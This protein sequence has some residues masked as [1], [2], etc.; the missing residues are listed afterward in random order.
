MQNFSFKLLSLFFIGFIFVTNSHAHTGSHDITLVYTG[1]IDGELEPCGCSEGGNKGGIKRRVNAI[2][3]LRKEDPNLYLISAG[4]VLVSDMPQ[5]RLKSEYLLKGFKEINYDAI[6]VQWRDLAFGSKFLIDSSLPFI[7]SNNT[8]GEFFGKSLINN[9]HAKIAFFS[10][11]DP[12]KSPQK[13]MKSDI[14][15]S[16]TDK[17]ATALKK[18]KS[19]KQLTI[20]SSTLSLKQAQ[21]TLP[22]D[23]VDILIIKAKYEQ[24]GD[25]Q[26]VNNMLVLQPGSRGMRI[27]K[28][29]L[30]VTNQGEMTTWKHKVI[31][32]PEETGDAPR[33]ADWY[34]QYNTKV[35][36]DYEKRVA[37]RKVLESG[38]SVFAGEASC[39]NCHA[40]QYKI[41]S[42]TRHAEAF[43]SLQDVN[44]AFDP[45][46]IG[47]HTVGF[48]QKGGFIDPAITENLMHVQCENCH[49]AA[50][51]HAESDGKIPV[52]NKDWPKEKMCSQCHVQK[53]SPD[54]K[55]EKY[56]PKI[57]H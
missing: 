2:D 50:R 15:Y 19:S 39:K 23:D 26:Q 42:N 36:E 56:W 43:Y 38:T 13:E 40:K 37:I 8:G 41:W 57:I 48:E 47:C 3:Q 24:Y 34:E 22:L 11:L 6:G 4:G 28:L 9:N 55:L 53:H 1:N 49:G 30:T 29:N 7:L 25:P 18:A 31:P 44:K 54:F 52:S 45:D 20:L 10:W 12:A 33:M 27:G 16:A 17:L 35:K 5:D 46:C 14:A 21:K 51:A 32:L